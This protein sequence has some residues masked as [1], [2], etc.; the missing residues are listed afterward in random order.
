M[1]MSTAVDERGENI[2]KFGYVFEITKAVNASLG[3]LVNSFRMF[4]VGVVGFEPTTP[5]TP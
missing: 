2:T 4:L 5:Y 1:L 3:R